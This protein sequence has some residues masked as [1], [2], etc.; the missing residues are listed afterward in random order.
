MS[1][2]PATAQP[3]MGK[4]IRLLGSPNEHE[5]LAS[6]NMLGRTLRA[7]GSDFNDLASRLDRAPAGRRS[8]PPMRWD[9]D[10]VA[11]PSPGRS[12]KR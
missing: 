5:R 6:L 8:A 2:L 4:L 1:A 9:P 10:L 11:A 7:G 3:R 12:R